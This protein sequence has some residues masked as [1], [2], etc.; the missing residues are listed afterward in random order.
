MLAIWQWQSFTAWQYVAS[1]K[2]TSTCNPNWSS[3]AQFGH[4]T[5]LLYTELENGAVIYGIATVPLNG[6]HAN[7]KRKATFLSF[8]EALS[9]HS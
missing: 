6:Y 7:G 9:D 2:Y 3:L 1:A 8:I 5:I 4:G